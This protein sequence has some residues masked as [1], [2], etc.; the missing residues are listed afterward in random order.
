MN[1]NDMKIKIIKAKFIR[2]KCIYII[3]LLLFK[4]NCFKQTILNTLTN[5]VKFFRTLLKRKINTYNNN[6]LKIFW[7]YMFLND[8]L[9]VSHWNEI[10]ARF[11]P[12][13]IVSHFTEF[14]LQ[15][16]FWKQTSN[17]CCEN[18]PS[19]NRM[20]LTKIDLIFHT[21]HISANIGHFNRQRAN[22]VFRPI[23]GRLFSL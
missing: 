6:V 13:L 17:I 18:R 14:F 12:L 11:L 19:A 9:F 22:F 21:M 1:L 4:L 8:L 10:H 20:K 5:F 7:T 23:V 16:I 3:K 2:N 15:F